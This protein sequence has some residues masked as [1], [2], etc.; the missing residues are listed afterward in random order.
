MY[1]YNQSCEILKKCA[2]KFLKQKRIIVFVKQV[3]YR[4]K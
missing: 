3:I 1:L 2:L 4:K